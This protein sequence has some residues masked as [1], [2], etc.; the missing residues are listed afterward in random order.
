MLSNTEQRMLLNLSSNLWK[1]L[2][3]HMNGAKL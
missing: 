1:N 3:Q 2:I